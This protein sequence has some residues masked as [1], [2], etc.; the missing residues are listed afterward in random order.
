MSLFAT[1][2][3]NSGHSNAAPTPEP[4]PVEKPIFHHVAEGSIN[5]RTW[6][7]AAGAASLFKRNNQYYLEIRLWNQTYSNP[8]D[9]I[10]G[11][12]LQTRVYVEN[13]E[14][15]GK[16]DPTDPFSL[17]PT[18]IFSDLTDTSYRNNMIAS[19]G[20]IQIDRIA[21]GR[22]VGSIQGDFNSSGVGKTEVDGNFDV[23]F[24]AQKNA[25]D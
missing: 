21:N 15:L 6:Q 10:V 17:I 25:L 3:Q 4:T 1:A 23:P 14:G 19:E 24:C 5:G 9:Q 11:S 7:F 22:V 12:T 13:R 20:F 16:I 18:I 8:C 2:C